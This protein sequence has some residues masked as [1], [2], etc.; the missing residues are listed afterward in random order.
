L[1]GLLGVHLRRGLLGPDVAAT[2]VADLHRAGRGPR[3]ISLH[4]PDLIA[5]GHVVTA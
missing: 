1:Y 5:T 3:Q 4:L 2:I